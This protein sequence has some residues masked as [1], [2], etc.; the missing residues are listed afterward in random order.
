MSNDNI[1][2]G[3]KVGVVVAAVAAGLVAFWTWDW[4]REAR[5]WDQRVARMYPNQRAVPGPAVDAY[6]RDILG[7][8][9]KE[10]TR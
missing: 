9:L 2:L 6:R 4:R 3:V 1:N 5:K 7:R 8:A 10:T